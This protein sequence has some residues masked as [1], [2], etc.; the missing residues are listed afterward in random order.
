MIDPVVEVTIGD[1][2]GN[3]EYVQT[4][5]NRIKQMSKPQSA[6]QKKEIIEL[7]TKVAK[8]NEKLARVKSLGNTTRLIES[9]A[10]QK[11]EL[12]RE[13]LRLSTAISDLETEMIQIRAPLFNDKHFDLLSGDFEKTFMKFPPDKKRSVIA[14]IVKNVVIKDR[15]VVSVELQPPFDVEKAER[16]DGD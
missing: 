12:E 15:G 7:K 11:L 14:T 5:K 4:I 3:K 2:L 8:L 9:Q 16:T 13:K 6:D 10:Q 1:L